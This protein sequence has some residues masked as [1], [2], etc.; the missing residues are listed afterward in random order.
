MGKVSQKRR[1]FEIRKRRE[2]RKKINKLKKKYLVA[3]TKEE[4]ERILEKILKIVPHYSIEEILKL[5][6]S[7]K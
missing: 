1:Q 2:K 5:D 7:Q 3:K 6:E 4:K